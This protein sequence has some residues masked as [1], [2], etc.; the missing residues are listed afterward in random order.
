SNGSRSVAVVQFGPPLHYRIPYHANDC[1]GGVDGY[2]NPVASQD[3]PPGQ[4][5]VPFMITTTN[6][7]Q[8]R[9]P[10]V[11]PLLSATIGNSDNPVTG[12]PAA[13]PAEISGDAGSWLTW[14]DG[15]CEGDVYQ[16]LGPGDSASAYG[17]VGPDTATE[18]RRI[19][20]YADWDGKED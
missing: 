8:Q 10:A 20:I 4:Y 5:M 15:K 11:Y 14:S 19:E 13:N 18:V 2:G 12:M 6:K 1:P 7:L 16:V 3:L 9:A 17:W